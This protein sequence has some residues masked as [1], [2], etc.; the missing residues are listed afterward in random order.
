MKW[1]ETPL[2]EFDKLFEP[3]SAASGW[4][5]PKVRSGVR[6]EGHGGSMVVVSS[7]SARV[8]ALDQVAYCGTKAAISML[9]KALGA[10]WAI[11]AC[12]SW[13]SQMIRTNVAHGCSPIRKPTG[14]RRRIPLHRHGEP[15]RWR[16]PLPS[17]FTMPSS[18]VTSARSWRTRERCFFFFDTDRARSLYPVEAFPP[19]KP[20]ISSNES[21]TPSS[22]LIIRF[23]RFS[24]QPSLPNTD[25]APA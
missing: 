22:P 25:P 21:G 2:P 3:T 11:S 7:I 12:R 20:L 23:P 24:T 4:S 1:D 6:K 9:G 15:R 14:L 10:S 5:A 8:G 18:Y 16:A 13:W 17:F 19:K